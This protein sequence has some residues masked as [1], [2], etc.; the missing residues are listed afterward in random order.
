MAYPWSEGDVLK[1]VDLNAAIGAALTQ[2]TQ[3][4][5][6]GTVTSVST[7]LSLVA[8]VLSSTVTGTVTSVSAGAG[9]SG[10][11][12]TSSGSL[13]ADWRGGSVTSLGSGLAL[14][15]G[16]LSSTG[17]GGTVTSVTA[18]AGLSGGPITSSG[19]LAADWRGGSVTS[20]GSGLSLVAGELT[21]S[22]SGGSVT[23]VTGTGTVSGLSLSGTVTGAGNITLGGSLSVAA[24]SM[25]ALTGDVT[26]SAGSVATTLAAGSASN[27]NSGTLPAGRLPA[28]TGDVTTS[29]GSAATTLATV[30]SNVGSFGDGTHVAAV[31]V[32]G[33]GLVTAA[34]SVAI[35]GAAPTGA[36]GGGLAGTYPNPTVSAVPASALPALTGDVTSS[37]G[38]A[39]TT[40]AAG[41]ASVLNSGTLLAARMPALTGD[42]TSSAGAVATTLATVNSNVGSFGDSTHV[43]SFTVNGKGLVT[44]ASSVALAPAFSSL[45]GTATYAQLPT[46]V[47]Q[48]PLAFVLPGRPSTGQVYNISVPFA[49]TI[50]ASLA[51]STVYDTTLTTS[52]AVFTVNKVTSGNVI[53]ALGTVTIT[54]STHFS[55]T[56]AG[57]GGSLAAGDVLQLVAPTQDATLADVGITIL[58]NRV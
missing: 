30:N 29:A 49:V 39:A 14:V 22:G 16:V 31:T 5:N 44:A 33:K 7:G 46:E 23:S 54:N 15:G 36:A 25:P 17:K 45:T 32:N 51:G 13:A 41:S 18:G 11:P 55:A 57:A 2:P 19:S 42:I 20:L 26:T 52:N 37:A 38:S 48:V 58:A 56:L 10:G 50:A 43:G 21:A 47:Q 12:I 40:L 35:T 34:S 6:A 1:A 4:W 28:L 8:G 27:L 24:G 3:F 53:S 9:L